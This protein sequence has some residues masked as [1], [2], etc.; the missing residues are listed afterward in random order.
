[1]ALEI[2]Q[3]RQPPAPVPHQ[4]CD[5]TLA[6]PHTKKKAPATGLN[7]R[8]GPEFRECVWLLFLLVPPGSPVG[9]GLAS[10]RRGRTLGR[11][12]VLLADSFQSQASGP[13]HEFFAV[14]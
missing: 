5:G 1:M 6:H 12:K 13:D 4:K 10:F 7:P 11:S 2:A 8:P 9:N 14:L 3:Y